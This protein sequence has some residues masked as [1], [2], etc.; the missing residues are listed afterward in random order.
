MLVVGKSEVRVGTP[1]S[2]CRSA[3]VTIW[4]TSDQSHFIFVVGC[5]GLSTTRRSAF[6]RKI[7]H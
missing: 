3:L 5:N 4:T 7:S 1:T 2:Q 6:A